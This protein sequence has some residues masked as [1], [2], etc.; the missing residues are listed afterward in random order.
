MT[1]SFI[2]E[3]RNPFTSVRGFI[4]LLKSEHPS[5]TYLDIISNELE[6][7]NFRI[8]QFLLSYKKRIDR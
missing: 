7:L 6:Q 4:Q 5:M 3:F 2:H 8:S 1:P